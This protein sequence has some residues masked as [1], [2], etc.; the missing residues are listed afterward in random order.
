MQPIEKLVQI[1]FNKLADTQSLVDY[2]HNKFEKHHFH[3]Q[4]ANNLILHIS[5]LSTKGAEKYRIVIEGN[6]SKLRISLKDVGN[7]VYTLIDASLNK[8][9]RQMSKIHE[10]RSKSKFNFR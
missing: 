7:D 10:K 2:I 3:L 4:N 1:K 6:I 5:K 9:D 8:L